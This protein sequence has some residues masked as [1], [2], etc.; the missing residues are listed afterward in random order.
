MQ[1]NVISAVTGYI[2]PAGYA[3]GAGEC[4]DD[5]P[6]VKKPERYVVGIR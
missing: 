1:G 2:T 3:V 5:V 6:S 4:L